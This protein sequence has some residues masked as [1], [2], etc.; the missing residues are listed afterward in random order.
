[1]AKMGRPKVDNPRKQNVSLRLTA[2]EHEDL[3]SYSRQHNQT[4][5]QT[6]V[7]GFYLLISQERG[8]KTEV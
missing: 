1:M 4:V 5:T 7:Q 8:E 6:I 3:L 2:K